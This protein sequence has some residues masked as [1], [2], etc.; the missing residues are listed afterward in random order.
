[1]KKLLIFVCYFISLGYYSC[2]YLENNHSFNHKILQNDR[3]I[4]KINELGHVV[5]NGHEYMDQVLTL[6]YQNNKPII[7]IRDDMSTVSITTSKAYLFEQWLTIQ[8]LK[9]YLE[10][11]SIHE[12][13]DSPFRLT[14]FQFKLE[15][16]IE[17]IDKKEPR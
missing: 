4:K 5:I 16:N 17:I 11:T 9:N 3:Y 12:I 6:T 15:T 2:D 14:S 1:M 7:W 13:C 8:G 10:K